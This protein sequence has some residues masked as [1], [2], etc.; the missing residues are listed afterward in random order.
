M[1][2][3]A[4]ALKKTRAVIDNLTGYPDWQSVASS[5]G[6]ISPSDIKKNPKKYKD[7]LKKAKQERLSKKLGG[8]G[9]SW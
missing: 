4:N 7:L 2:I 3:I 5:T 1:A 9:G 6:P 8:G